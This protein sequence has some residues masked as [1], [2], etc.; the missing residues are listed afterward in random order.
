MWLTARSLPCYG[1]QKVWHH[2][3]LNRNGL[4]TGWV[5]WTDIKCFEYKLKPFI[6]ISTFYWLEFM[7]SLKHCNLQIELWTNK[8]RIL[9]TQDTNIQRIEHKHTSDIEHK[10]TENRHKHT[11]DIEHKHTENRHKHTENRHKHTENRHKHTSD[12]EHKHTENRQKHTSDIEHK[13]TE[14]RH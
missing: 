12:I 2:P 11:S 6:K 1:S 9:D 3:S 10:H 4:E 8:N 5:G 7:I 13:H 14:K